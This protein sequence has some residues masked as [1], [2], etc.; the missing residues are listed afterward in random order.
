LYILW[1]RI[2]IIALTFV[3]ALIVAGGVLLLI[4]SR[5]DAVATGTIDPGS[6]NP[7]TEGPG[8]PTAIGL[9]QGNL[10]QLVQ[11]HRVA[12]DVVKRLN[13]TASP[14]VQAD[15]RRSSSFGRESIDDWMAESISKAVDPKFE[16]GTNVLSIKYKAADPNQAALIA[17]TY[18]AATIDAS[19]AMKAASGDQTARWFAPQLDDL[20]KDLLTARGAL[21]QF[22]ARTNVVAPSAA[23]ADIES[24]G[25]LAITQDLSGNRALLTALQS[26]LDSGSTD[27]SNDPS[28]PD[29]QI[30]NALKE[31]I[32]SAQADI[33]AGKSSL[34]ANNPRMITASTNLATMNKQLADAKDKARQHLKE[35]I[36][37]TQSQVASLGVAQA[38]AQKTLIAAQAQRDRFSDLQRDVAFKMDELNARERTASQARLQSKLTFADIAVLDKASAPI[39]PAFPKPTSVMPAAIAGGL[40]LG[41]I[42]ALIAEATDRRI[43]FPADFSIATSAPLLGIID[44]SKRRKA[45]GG[46]HSRSLLTAS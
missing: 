8:S 19:I 21:E 35:K 30:I 9:G 14:L 32:T 27:L 46:G 31:K 38:Q 36:A 23:G 39:T 40:T 2:W 34:G 15:Y 37:S 43:R 20:R 24:A 5:Y 18:L 25:L 6:V 16:F 7:L 13:L 42:L 11:S 26:R 29:L 45:L 3:F 22:Q 4:P 41:M 10:L 12:V 28:D 44:A 17:N 1:R 33:E